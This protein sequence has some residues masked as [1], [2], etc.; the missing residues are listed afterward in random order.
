[1][2]EQ[3]RERLPVAST[4]IE[5]QIQ[6]HRE[7]EQSIVE[8]MADRTNMPDTLHQ[9]LNLSLKKIREDLGRLV[10]GNVARLG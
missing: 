8:S 7:I 6:N 5:R 9:E 10:T 2:T 3:Y 1:M 4:D